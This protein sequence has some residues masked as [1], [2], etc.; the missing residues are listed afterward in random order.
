ML[1]N[2]KTQRYINTVDEKYTN[3]DFRAIDPSTYIGIQVLLIIAQNN[4]LQV[5]HIL[6]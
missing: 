6:K 2:K 1:A 5:T 4:R 3:I